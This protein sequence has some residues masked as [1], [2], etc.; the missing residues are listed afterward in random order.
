MQLVD[1]LSLSVEF[2]CFSTL[3]GSKWVATRALRLGERTEKEFQYP[4]RVEVGCNNQRCVLRA[5]CCAFQYP[6][7]VEVGCNVERA[8][9]ERGLQLM[10]QYP[11]RVEVG[12][13]HTVR[14]PRALRFIV[15]VPSTGR[16]GLQRRTKAR[17]RYS[18]CGFSTLYGSKWVATA[19]SNVSGVSTIMFQYPLR[20]EV[21]C[22]FSRSSQDSALSAVSVPSTGRSGLQLHP[23]DQ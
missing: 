22:N 15:S 12:C 23:F 7:R 21:G 14:A 6:L 10:F 9:L 2:L 18:A 16:S 5:K 17:R 11:L 13:N 3:Y 1:S 4:L 8:A 19:N 20:V